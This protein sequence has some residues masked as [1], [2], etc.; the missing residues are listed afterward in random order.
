MPDSSQHLLIREATITDA[1]ALAEYRLQ[2]FTEIESE[3]STDDA[4]AFVSLCRQSFEALLEFGICN[5]WLA[6]DPG[7]SDPIG[8]LVM[9]KLPRLPTFKNMRTVEGY[10]INVYVDPAYRRNG[11]ASALMQAAIDYARKEEYARI[12]LRATETGQGVYDRLGFQCKENV[13]ELALE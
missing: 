1:D 11:I 2:M 13:M 6:E 5:A 4:I 3:P 7:E 12:R 9:L 10:I 8:T